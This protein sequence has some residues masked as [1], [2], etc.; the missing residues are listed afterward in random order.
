MGLYQKIPAKFKITNYNKQITNKS[1]IK[2]YKLQK[3]ILTGKVKMPGAN[4]LEFWSL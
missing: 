3:R 4:C 2:N 1:Q